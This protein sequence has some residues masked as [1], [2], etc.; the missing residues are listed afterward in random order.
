MQRLY[1]VAVL[2]IIICGI[3]SADLSSLLSGYLESIFAHGLVLCTSVT[4]HAK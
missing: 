2:G 1:L 4:L 3:Y